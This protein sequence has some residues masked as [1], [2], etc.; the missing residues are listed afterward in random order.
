[1][2]RLPLFDNAIF[3]NLTLGCDNLEKF[4]QSQLIHTPELNVIEWYALR[5]LFMISDSITLTDL[6]EL[7]GKK[8]NSFSDVVKNL[9]KHNYITKKQ[10]PF[11]HRKKILEL[12]DKA[13]QIRHDFL[14]HAY[15]LDDKINT[16][17]GNSDIQHMLQI[18]SRLK[19]MLI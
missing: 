11:D 12:T 6:A 17:V 5:V 3:I 8:P 14:A 19:Q 10:H 16:Y 18:L 1:M 13:K 15:D 2:I 4:I 7:F 9:K